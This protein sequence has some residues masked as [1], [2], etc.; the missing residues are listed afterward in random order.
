MSPST[1]LDIVLPQDVTSP[2]TVSAA[3]RPAVHLRGIAK[4]FVQRGSRR[5][6]F[7]DLDLHLDLDRVN[8]LFGPNGSGKSTLL[9][10]LAGLVTPDAG[11]IE[12]SGPWPGGLRPVLLHAGAGPGVLVPRLTVR[13]NI[14]WF[15]AMGDYALDEPLLDTLLRRLDLHARA[16]DLVEGLSRGQQQKALLVR[17][18]ACRT[19]L[20]LLDE[21]T[22]YLDDGSV[23]ILADMLEAA[24]RNGTGFV[25]ATHDR[26]LRAIRASRSWR[27]AC[28]VFVP[29]GDADHA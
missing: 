16:D 5:R 18:L 19:D 10:V 7:D 20:V 26:R 6:V 23:A 11:R 9:R 21:P 2:P 14:R 4:T 8:L 17:A 27:S 13:E 25:V 22:E 15:A 12:F 1:L 24:A 3:L 29:D 28:G